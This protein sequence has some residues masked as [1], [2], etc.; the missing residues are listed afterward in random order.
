MVGWYRIDPKDVEEAIKV[1]KALML[2]EYVS[3]NR[4]AI[5]HLYKVIDSFITILESFSPKQAQKLRENCMKLTIALNEV[6][7]NFITDELRNLDEIHKYATII[8][9]LTGVLKAYE[10]IFGA[11]LKEGLMEMLNSLGAIPLDDLN[12]V[13]G[14]EDAQVQR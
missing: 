3:I 2:A 9:T 10:T 14:D 12:K 4:M 13:E 5:D 11:R 6:I 8:I 7:D 1:H